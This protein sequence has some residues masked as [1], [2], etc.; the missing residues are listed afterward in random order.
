LYKIKKFAG[1]H[2]EVSSDVSAAG[3][4]TCGLPSQIVQ[5]SE[6]GKHV[7]FEIPQPVGQ[8][9]K[10]QNSSFMNRRPDT[11]KDNQTQPFLKIW[12]KVVCPRHDKRR[13]NATKD[14]RFLNL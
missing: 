9:F 4:A 10:R 11:T 7:Q 12:G 6:P 5:P 14:D 8:N 2:F 13:Q 3:K 1:V